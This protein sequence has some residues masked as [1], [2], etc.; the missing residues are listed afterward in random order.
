MM[1]VLLLLYTFNPIGEKDP[2]PPIANP[3]VEAV[4]ESPLAAPVVVESARFVGWSPVLLL[5]M[6][7][8][9]VTPGGTL[10]PD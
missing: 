5:V 2:P 1:I 10:M 8:F 7:L 4:S 6:R 3:P 9:N